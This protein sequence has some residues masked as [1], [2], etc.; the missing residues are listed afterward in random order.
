[1]RLPTRLIA[2]AM[3]FALTTFA[4]ATPASADD[5]ETCAKS[6]GDVAIAACTRA[7]ASGKYKGNNLA[8][9]YR[10]RAFEWNAKRQ[11]DRAIADDERAVAEYDRALPL[12]SAANKGN[13]DF[14]RLTVL[15]DLKRF[16]PAAVDLITLAKEFPKEIQSV[17]LRKIYLVVNYLREQNRNEDALATLLWLKKAN[18]RGP[19][20]ISPSE[21]LITLLIGQ[22]VRLKR[23]DE[24]AP[25]IA[26]LSQYTNLLQLVAD[27][28]NEPLWT[29]A[30]VRAV[31]Q[32]QDFPGRD[33]AAAQKLVCNNPRRSASSTVW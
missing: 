26:E 18:Y 17:Q 30:K 16:A 7:I 29:S 24:A 9:L 14:N 31:L 2:T 12:A 33:L 27:K 6:S 8:V 15:I 22:Y 25:Y 19:D 3:A 20:A 32:L 10:Y 11:S 23:A 21:G 1:M 13:I 5:F 28:E 4:G